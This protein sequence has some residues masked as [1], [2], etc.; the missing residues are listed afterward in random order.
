MGGMQEKLPSCKENQSS[1]VSN[2]TVIYF[3]CFHSFIHF[4]T[5]FCRLP[6]EGKK[7]ALISSALPY[8]NNV[9]HLGNIIG[10]VLSADVFARYFTLQ[11]NLILIYLIE[12]DNIIWI[13]YAPDCYSYKIPLI[14]HPSGPI[15]GTSSAFFN[16]EVY[17]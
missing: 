1:N 3:P 6:V 16:S 8:V 12:Q 17:F 14:T 13:G 5:S 9:P 10:C 11:R 4:A 2:L 7:N 15:F